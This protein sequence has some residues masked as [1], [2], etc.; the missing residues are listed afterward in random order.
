MDQTDISIPRSADSDGAAIPRLA[1]GVQLLG[2]YDS[3]GLS[4]QRYLAQRPDG[5]VVLLSELLYLTAGSLDG[6]RELDDVAREVTSQCDRVLTS[7]DVSYLVNTKLRPLGLVSTG[8]SLP[9]ATAPRA[10]PIL[11]LAFRAVLVPAIAVR[12]IAKV[13]RPLFFMPVI[14]AV[15]LGLG[16]SDAWLFT[17]HLVTPAFEQVFSRP[18]LI[19]AAAGLLFAAMLFHEVGHATACRFGGGNPGSI[20][21]GVYLM[22]PALYTNVTDSYRLDRRSRLRTDLGGIYFNAVFIVGAAAAFR[23]TR[24]APLVV[25]IIVSQLEMLQ[26]MLPVV[27][28]DGYYVLADL[29]G[30]PDLFARIRPIMKS[31]FGRR[32]VDVSVRE[33]T[34]R[35]RIVVTAWVLVVVPLLLGSLGLLLVHMPQFVAH[36]YSAVN[37][38]LHK[39]LEAAQKGDAGVAIG[40]GLSVVFLLVPVLGLSAV[41][42]RSVGAARRCVAR[43]RQKFCRRRQPGRHFQSR[44]ARSGRSLFRSR[45]S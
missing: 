41:L 19:V 45:S 35:T 2:A 37:A 18:L 14:I 11:A 25:I 3:Q 8:P 15:L 16:V 1:E 27:R 42:V 17:G 10:D 36:T 44:Q 38:N 31:F 33:L 5:Q 26:Q 43:Q 22:F 29:V 13:F 23:Y 21:A 7:G 24:F 20:G 28:F 9:G 30:V 4:S 39:A 40:E 6:Q 32:H 12:A 34:A